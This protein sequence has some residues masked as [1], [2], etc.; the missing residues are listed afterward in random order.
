MRPGL[1]FFIFAFFFNQAP[2]QAV[3]S[4]ELL[5]LS[6]EY[7]LGWTSHKHFLGKRRQNY[8]DELPSMTSNRQLNRM[9]IRNRSCY[10][11]N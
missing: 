3:D 1:H 8:L 6:K 9:P 2:A 11:R 5:N 7:L 10:S 4:G